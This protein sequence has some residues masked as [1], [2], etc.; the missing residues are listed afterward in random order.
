M[1]RAEDS[2]NGLLLHLDPISPNARR[3]SMFIAE[4]NLSI[5]TRSIRPAEGTLRSPEYLAMNPLGQIPLLQ[6]PSDLFLA[7]SMAIIELAAVWRC[8][9]RPSLG[10]LSRWKAEIDQRPSAVL[11]RYMPIERA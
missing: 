1:T 8:A 3:V 5:P 10:A 11:A 9:P 7:E 2:T 4:K 6:G